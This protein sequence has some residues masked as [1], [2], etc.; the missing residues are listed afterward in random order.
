MMTLIYIVAALLV[1]VI[2]LAAIAPK[3]YN[4]QR[5]ITIDKPKEIVFDYMRY[6]KN[7]EAWSPW[8]KKDPTMKITYTGADGQVGSKSSWDGNKE[9][10]TGSQTISTIEE[11]K[12]IESKLVFLKPWKSESVGY[13][14]FEDG[15]PGQTK[16]T[17]GFNGKN[18]FPA[19]IFMLAYNMDKAVGK[20]FT[21]GL[22]SLKKILEDV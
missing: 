19:T 18:K 3:T 22:E 17:W 8:H 5:S 4:V 1:I 10:G 13:Y 6:L 12:L 2:I 9:V 16:L 15:G 20:D 7:Y 11:Y 21:E 14:N